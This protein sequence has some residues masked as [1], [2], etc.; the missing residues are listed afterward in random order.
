MSLAEILGRV[1]YSGFDIIKYENLN[2]E[3]NIA[4]VREKDPNLKKYQNE[5]IIIGLERMG[6]NGVIFSLFKMRTMY[7][8]SEFVHDLLLRNNGFSKNGKI[9]NDIRLTRYGKVLR[10]YYIDELPQLINFFKGQ[11]KLV[12]F[13][14]VSSVYFDKLPDEL[15]NSRLKNKPGCIPPYVAEGL[16]PSFENACASEINYIRS[17]N[18]KPLKTDFQYFFKAIF[19]LVFKSIRSQ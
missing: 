12:G 14:A 16:S 18:K 2:F 19:N 9:E 3:Y 15:K 6:K 11:L 17:Y 7:P 8:F 13:R 1:Y 5:G 4:C 10:K